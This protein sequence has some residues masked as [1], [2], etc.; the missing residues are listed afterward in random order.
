M[1]S[2]E[3]QV[4][5]LLATYNGAAFL[6]AQLQSICEQDHQN[7]HVILSNDHSHDDT[8]DIARNY[9]G[10]RR[11]GITNGPGTGLAQN[12]W[13][14]LK[15]VPV[16]NYGAFCDQDDVWREDKLSRALLRLSCL[17]TPALY[18]S[19]RYVTNA[20]LSEKTYQPR[21]AVGSF[22]QLLCRNPI[23]GHTVVLNPSAVELLKQFPPPSN[24]P[25]HDWW[26]GLVLKGLGATFVHDPY[27]SLLYRQH[28]DN[29]F[30]AK[31]GRM[32]IIANGTYFK[33]HRANCIGLFH[34]R[35]KLTPNAQRALRICLPARTG[36]S[37]TQK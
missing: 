26:T 4:S 28:N 23:A 24:V 18:S 22:A 32:R 1:N 11:L 29:V 31:G 2:N 30:G 15:Q 6:P 16:G 20:T 9:I 37:L 17:K 14:A 12:F 8:R 5:I 35:D 27:P 7:W 19:G 33:W 21:R 10:A 13:N 25:F 3:P 36:I 34:I